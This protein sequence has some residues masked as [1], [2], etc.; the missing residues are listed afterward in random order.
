MSQYATF[1]SYPTF[2]LELTFLLFSFFTYRELLTCFG[3]VCNNWHLRVW[4]HLCRQ[5]IAIKALPNPLERLAQFLY[6]NDISLCSRL[7]HLVVHVS[8]QDYNMPFSLSWFSAL[9]SLRIDTPPCTRYRPVFLLEQ[10]LLLSSTLHTLEIHGLTIGPYTIRVLAGQTSLR[11]LHLTETWLD[12][13]P[14]TSLSSLTMLHTLEMKKDSDFWGCK[15]L[16]WCTQLRRLRLPHFNF[17][18]APFTALRQLEH[19]DLGEH[20]PTSDELRALVSLPH[21]TSLCSISE[22]S[23]LACSCLR[24]F[25]LLSE[26]F[27]LKNLWALSQLEELVI[28]H[29]DRSGP[30]PLAKIGAWLPHLRIIDFRTYTPIDDGLYAVGPGVFFRQGGGWCKEGPIKRRRMHD[31]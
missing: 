24:R 26:Q 14:G 16:L 30:F 29:S 5:G 12:L 3:P 25:H 13:A 10:D 11:E 21:L 2:P 17:P 1:P 18:L 15:E 20:K 22:P 8:G 27:T 23:L 6:R 28:S 7:R 9:R 4:Q 31:E 19:L